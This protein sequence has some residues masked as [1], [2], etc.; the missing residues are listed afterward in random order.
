M[1]DTR[2]I[3]MI[4]SYSAIHPAN[5]NPRVA[6]I[7]VSQDWIGPSADSYEDEP[8]I[9]VKRCLP[10]KC[11][12]IWKCDLSTVNRDGASPQ[13]TLQ[14]NLGSLVRRIP[15]ILLDWIRSSCTG[16]WRRL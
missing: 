4:S 12:D 15:A 6:R 10:L 1:S 7:D 8:I 16:T 2:Y 14:T 5:R 13:S 9:V 11:R 3:Y